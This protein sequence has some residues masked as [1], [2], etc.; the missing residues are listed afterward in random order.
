[1][2]KAINTQEAPAAIGPYSQ[3]IR[4]GDFV[5]TSGQIGLDAAGEIISNDVAVQCEQVCKNLTAVLGA[6][7]CEWKQVV[8]ATIFLS[9][10]DD[11]PIVNEIYGKRLADPPP[12]RATVAV[13]T[14][15]KH[16]KVEIDVIAYA[17]LA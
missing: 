9:S 13:R 16:V 12:A 2:I 10:M 6:A 11:F 8:K 14:L 3:A 17:P 5:Y 15:P 1:M 4:A 7:Q